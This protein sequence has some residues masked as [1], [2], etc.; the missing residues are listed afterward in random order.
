MMYALG[1]TRGHAH[2]AVSRFSHAYRLTQAAGTR[3]A[4][5]ASSHSALTLTPSQSSLGSST[6]GSS[7][8]TCL[9][10][11]F[12]S[13]SAA[14]ASTTATPAAA[15]AADEEGRQSAPAGGTPQGQQ[16]NTQN[17][18]EQQQQERGKY[19]ESSATGATAGG[20]HP[21]RPSILDVDPYPPEKLKVLEE[22]YKWMDF[23]AMAKHLHM[24]DVHFFDQ[25][26]PYVDQ[27]FT[28]KPD[29]RLLHRLNGANRLKRLQEQ[30]DKKIHRLLHFGYWVT[31]G[32][33]VRVASE[34]KIQSMWTM[35]VGGDMNGTASFGFGKGVDMAIAEKRALED[36]RRNMLFVPLFESRTISHEI[37][38]RHGVCQV[39]MWPRPRERGL[40]AGMIPRMI[41]ECFGIRD[42]T[43]KVDG[44]ALPH[45]Q[46]MAIFNG[47]REVKSL[48]EEAIRRGV[49][50]HR[51]FE[52]GIEKPRHPGR[53]EVV[54]RGREIASLLREVRA[55]QNHETIMEDLGVNEELG[56]EE[57][58]Y[59]YPHDPEWGEDA[60][61]QK[62][63][64]FV[65]TYI[66]R[67][68]Q[69]LDTGA[70]NASPKYPKYRRPAIKETLFRYRGLPQP[71]TPK[72]EG[73][74]KIM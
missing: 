64:T 43:A 1:R 16:D 62:A 28:I 10:R 51:M 69:P 35:V 61:G 70:H 55:I 13:G 31:S 73:I 72:T 7:S 46:A 53:D 23:N 30:E 25:E 17:E 29:F 60:H 24:A 3:A 12:A 19:A 6:L 71:R 48:R 54:R 33:N 67:K 44:R 15:A 20:S 50:A 27:D 58:Q 42:I 40:T 59:T 38:G 4:A 34:G 9:T 45:H 74:N 18:S 63:D 26:V 49:T 66:E 39:R 8:S 41:F 47:L 65:P 56:K 68:P 22:K 52:R 37:R 32:R 11:S 5:A 57:D 36:L 21:Q 14:G 2:R